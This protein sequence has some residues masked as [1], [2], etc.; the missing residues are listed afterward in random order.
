V[1]RFRKLKYYLYLVFVIIVYPVAGQVNIHDVV[2]VYAPIEEVFCKD[3]LNNDTL[4]VADLTGF[5]AGDT[6]MV[7]QV[8]GA[9]VD[10]LNQG[11]L[12]TY[13]YNSG[14][15]AIMKI[16]SIQTAGRL[17]FLNSTL[18]NMNSYHLGEMG[19]LI[20]VPSYRRARV[21]SRLY[22]ED[23]DPSSGT[24]GVVA[25]YVER[26][27]ELQADIDVSGQGFRGAQPDEYT[28]SCSSAD[29]LAY[30]NLFF[31]EAA[32]DT[33][34]HSGEGIADSAF[35]YTRGR[36]RRINGGGG[37]NGLYSGGGGGS[38]YNAGGQGG[39]ESSSCNSTAITNGAGGKGLAAQYANSGIY[40][41]RVFF[42]GGGGTGTQNTPL[43][44]ATA[45]G[46]GGGI[47]V[48]IADSI[49]GNGYS[50][51]A[52]GQSVTDSATAGGGGG[53]AGGVIV[54]DVSKVVN[55]SA[56]ALGGDGGDT[57]FDSDTTGPGGGGGGG[58]YWISGVAKPGLSFN[59]STSG[60]AGEA[61]KKGTSNGDT[62][63]S[64][65][66][67][68]A[69]ILWN[70]KTPLRGF[71]FNTTPEGSTV[72]SDVIPSP[73]IG[74]EPKGGTGT[75]TYSW[76]SRTN[77]TSWSL[78]SGASARDLSF[79]SPLS[80]TTYFR[81]I[82]V[83][84]GLTDTSAVII[85]NVQPQITGNLIG[86]HDTVCY[87]NIALPLVSKGSI[88]GGPAS[89]VPSSY[90]YTWQQSSDGS[91]W[92]TATGIV[93]NEGYS[94]PAL[95]DTTFYRR[96]VV[97][98]VCDDTSNVATITVLSTLQGNTI[99]PEQII[100]YN[101]S[102]LPLDGA[103]LT[104]GLPSDRR[105]RWQ[106]SSSESGT[107]TDAA[108]TQIY[109]PGPLLDSVYYRRIL[110]SGEQ[111]ECIDT[112]NV[113]PVI[114]LSLIGNNTISADDSVCAGT[115]VDNLT[116]LD[117]AGGDFN[118][119]HLWQS[120]V[121]LISWDSID[122]Y[123]LN[124]PFDPG[125]LNDTTWFRRI[126]KSGQ[127]NVCRDTSNVIEIS[128]LPV[129]SN[130]IIP[131]ADVL[132][133]EGS[134]FPLLNA[135][136]PGGGNNSYMYFW[137]QS[138]NDS[139]NW[140]APGYG[141]TDTA[142][143]DP[144]QRL[145]TTYF[146]RIVWSGENGIC[147]DTSYAWEGLVQ[148]SVRNN[149]INSYMVYTCYNSAPDLLNGTSASQLTGGDESNYTFKWEERDDVTAYGIPA[150]TSTGEDYQA[151]ALTSARY[152]R[153][154]VSSGVCI[155]TTE[156]VSVQINTLPR[157]DLVSSSDTICEGSSYNLTVSFTGSPNWTVNYNDNINGNTEVSGLS[158]DMSLIPVNPATDDSLTFV[159]TIT[160]LTDGNGCVA[161]ADSLFGS[162]TLRV[163]QTPV[164]EITDRDVQVCDTMASLGTAPDNGVGTWAMVSGPGTL[165]FD[166]LH[167]EEGV[168]RI[169][170]NSDEFGIYT[171]S[172]TRSSPK[173]PGLPDQTTITFFEDPEPAYAGE[174]ITVYM[175]GKT[176]LNAD[177]PTAGEGWWSVLDGPGSVSDTTNPSS[178]V[179][180][181]ILQREGSN[182]FLWTVGNGVCAETFDT[183]TISFYPEKHYKGFSPNGDN[184]NDYFVIWGLKDADDFDFVV[185][186]SM[187]A[188][189]RE[190][191]MDDMDPTDL[192]TQG[193]VLDELKLWDG[194]A[195]N[196]ITVPD[197]TYYYVIQIRKDNEVIQ[198]IKDFVIVR[199]R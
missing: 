130:N 78:V 90:N 81:R 83:S 155:D 198:E 17:V 36:G 64:G 148:D 72:C 120:S 167:A 4:R 94:V 52:N 115:D 110:Y 105:F 42:G 60:Q 71:L 186:N 163:Y 63:S 7:Y 184:I 62:Y 193:E 192:V 34:A 100:C 35:N 179:S 88:A 59:I 190:L 67:T 150:Q 1:L 178:L 25:L 137:E 185:F 154:I 41:N 21:T 39:N 172:W 13:S 169:N 45:G 160:S 142:I 75:Y 162:A 171:V 136:K 188:I 103:T 183:L 16:D 29:P 74:S 106:S 27:L 92:N 104:G 132:L 20:R 22:A 19:Q 108:T 168:L 114:V 14:K 47:V 37:G 117:P 50:I 199:T 96:I 127:N 197:G 32:T 158:S 139:L 93:S 77:S 82:V 187:G 166:D 126:V 195:D 107:F 58:M 31:I 165:L 121:D 133:C 68:P 55:T 116:G 85:I 123:I 182:V 23:W 65:A 38:N 138:E 98:G 79:T 175:E 76:I 157:A 109:S 87:G 44:E 80:D 18:P 99:A 135:L 128:V 181:L 122:Q 9:E 40:I 12:G 33:A 57:Y 69:G 134:D 11:V 194:K 159:Y 152:Y 151:E 112:S 24:G 95:Y 131:T 2:N 177:A 144:G 153:R 70:L 111:D 174:D 118:Y 113:L 30:S 61:F 84:G 189:I 141:R 170:N 129:I 46:N 54:L 51:R 149:E 26:S 5:S 124:L 43:M 176:L 143:Y 145:V 89:G 15:Y 101:T 66:G 91:S 180:N 97:A 161:P 48:I 146:R 8:K 73:I 119:R 156:E 6:V 140:T 49:I 56:L 147:R 164:A 53:G 173:C 196:G 102:P 10:T 191:T 3:N 125:V 28:G 86:E